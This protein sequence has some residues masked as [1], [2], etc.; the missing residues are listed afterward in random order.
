MGALSDDGRDSPSER[1]IAEKVSI[2]Y[3]RYIW[4]VPKNPP[5]WPRMGPLER[6]EWEKARKLIQRLNE[7]VNELRCCELVPVDKAYW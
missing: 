5:E 6:A 4:H 2:Y 1:R 7:V 3:A